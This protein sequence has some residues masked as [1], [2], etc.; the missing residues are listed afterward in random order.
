MTMDVNREWRKARE[1]KAKATEKGWMGFCSGWSLEELN[2][3]G[4]CWL[5]IGFQ[6]NRINRVGFSAWFSKIGRR[7]LH[8]TTM[9]LFD[10]RS[11]GHQL[12]YFIAFIIIMLS[13]SPSLA[14]DCHVIK[15]RS[16]GLYPEGLTW[17]PSAQHF[18][19]GSLRN[20]TLY[21]ISDAAVVYTLLSDPSLP[22]NSSILGLAV[23]SR[24]R[25]LLAAIH[26]M[27]PL[28][29]FNALASYD[30]RSLRPIFLSP[31]PPDSSA[32]SPSRDIA[33]AI[34]VDYEG[35]AYVTN[36]GNNFIW[37]VNIDGEPSIFSRSPLFT[38]YPVDRS[39]PYSY[40]G[41]NGIVY[42][43]MGYLLV[44][45]SNTGKLFKVDAVDGKA[46][47]VIL[48]EELPLADDVAV[49]RDGVVVVVSPINGAWF[50]KSRDSWG[51]GVV[52]DRIALDS[53]RFPTS[54]A[55][56]GGQ[57]VY[58]LYGH[59]DEGIK[60]KVEREWFSIEE[61][62]SGKEESG[63]DNVW[64]FVLIGLGLAYFLFW[65]FQMGQLVKN[66]NKKTA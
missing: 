13:V 41:L 31:L 37:K 35:N 54:V 65:R 28:P 56:G 30:L 46:R 5:W 62:R 52:V 16:P 34:A 23:D 26:S 60:D 53:E 9:T 51:E 15:F 4:S 49:R 19:V 57:R 17:D 50:L 12:I 58:V 25:R 44:V 29:P 3:M 7:C 64:A 1:R 10:A 21:S 63:V 6:R 11:N 66:M 2:A 22:P 61:I 47:V 27:E 24:H 55:I 8:P 32:L 38:R 36:S 20:R 45:Q 14:A 42:V 48:N 33:N 39:S 59:V 18:I 43:S 40:S